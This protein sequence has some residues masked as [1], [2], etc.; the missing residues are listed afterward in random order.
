MQEVVGSIPSG[1]TTLRPLG[2]AWHSHGDDQ[3][4]ACHYGLIFPNSLISPSHVD[5]VQ[6]VLDGARLCSALEKCAQSAGRFVDK[7][8]T[9]AG[10]MENLANM[11]A[12]WNTSDAA[13]KRRLAEES[14]EHNVHFV[15]PNH[16]IIGRDAFL[17]MVDQVQAEIPGA[18]YSRASEVD[19]QNNHCRYHW[20]I[21]MNGQLIMPGFDVTEVNDAGKIV[22]VIG[23]FQEIERH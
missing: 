19:I 22:K 11:M 14:M 8:E 4:E 9:M 15:D 10:Y 23:F 3:S 7:E 16:N 1:S 20:A 18:D 6:Y 17:K 2:Y 5:S 12:I 21:H 13:E